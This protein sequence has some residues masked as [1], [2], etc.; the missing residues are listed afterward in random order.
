[1]IL[2][3]NQLIIDNMNTEQAFEILEKGLNIASTKGA[4]ALKDAAIL[5]QAL[6]VIRQ[7][8]EPQ[9]GQKLSGPSEEE[10]SK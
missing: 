9:V 3:L 6:E 5:Q 1:M 8:I 2:M 7:S 10:K 4:F